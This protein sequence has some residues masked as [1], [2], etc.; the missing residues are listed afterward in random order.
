MKSILNIFKK[1]FISILLLVILGISLLYFQADIYDFPQPK[2]FSGDSL[3][4]PYKSIVKQSIKC[5][6]HAH[7]HAWGGLTNGHNTPQD[8]TAAYKAKGYAVAGVSNY[9]CV[10]DSINSSSPIYIPVYEHGINIKKAHKLAI[11]TEG[12]L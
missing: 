1:L 5:N 7:T 4:N 2:R 3:I 9:H 10:E 8:L 12:P 11:N 6:F